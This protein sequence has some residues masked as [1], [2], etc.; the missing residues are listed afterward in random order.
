MCNVTAYAYFETKMILRCVYKIYNP[1]IDLYKNI[2]FPLH[3]IRYGFFIF[4]SVLSYTF[5]INIFIH[6]YLAYIYINICMERKVYLL[7]SML[8]R[9]TFLRIQLC[10][11]KLIRFAM[12]LNL[13][14]FFFHFRCVYIFVQMF[15]YHY[16]G[17]LYIIL[18]SC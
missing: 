10:I 14:F 8:F 6:I 16:E 15:L 1:I 9:V 2:R 18:F 13:F 4:I 5:C 3:F 11:I 17:T 12:C 7:Y